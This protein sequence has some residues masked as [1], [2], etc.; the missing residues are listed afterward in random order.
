MFSLPDNRFVSL[1]GFGDT[2]VIE[3]AELIPISGKGQP[4]CFTDESAPRDYQAAERLIWH[5]GVLRLRAGG[6]Q[7]VEI[8]Q[9]GNL[10]SSL[11]INGIDLRRCR[12]FADDQ[13][14]DVTGFGKLETVGLRGQKDLSD[15][16]L[17][18]LVTVCSPREI[19]LANTS[20]TDETLGCLAGISGL[21]SLD[22]SF[23]AITDEGLASIEGC[24]SLR[25]LALAG[26][27]I[28][29]AGVQ[30]LS[31]LTELAELDLSG[32]NISGDG[33]EK[34]KNL[35]GLE[36][37][38]LDH[39]QIQD[40]DM[41]HLRSTPTLTSL[42]LANTRVSDA[43]LRELDELKGLAE[44][45]VV[46]TQV[47]TGGV[48]AFNQKL[49]DCRVE[50]Q[51]DAPVDLLKLFSI[52]R[53]ADTGGWT[54]KQEA[55]VSS[56]GKWPRVKIPFLPPEEYLLDVAAGRASRKD[57]GLF[58]GLVLGGQR[59]GVTINTILAGAIASGL[60]LVDGRR[61][62]NNETTVAGYPLGDSE[63][64]TIR[65]VVRK[66]R[67]TVSIDGRLIIDW[68]G[69]PSRLAPYHWQGDFD[70]NVLALSSY[71]TVYR[72]TKMQITPI[73]S[74]NRNEP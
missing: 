12:R 2:F 11:V 44:T 35:T 6:N 43:G 21:E 1:A 7:P 23:T 28:S 49:P 48:A 53:K 25:R 39:T 18:S 38:M 30:H 27:Q 65:V 71:D 63:A 8:N 45:C 40:A 59:F 50:H 34:L 60:E 67:I 17:E 73:S 5:G 36:R 47:T 26:T 24:K 66:S 29:D 15:T 74:T 62:D 57:G 14:T 58:L 61:V 33:L 64:F 16:A 46:G 70:E 31:K 72:I 22:L 42:S 20:I 10:P 9:V 55:L 54:F 68:H 3:S 4:L 41:A 52:H 69:D 37:L 51:G 13:L 56:G 19:D 32:T